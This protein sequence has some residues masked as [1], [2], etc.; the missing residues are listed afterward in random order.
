MI[1]TAVVVPC[2]DEATRL[3]ADA[4]ARFCRDTPWAS[5]VFVNDGSRDRTL[6]VL[7]S[8]AG[9]HP[10]RM[11]VID[12]QPNQGKAG[13]RVRPFDFVTAIVELDRVRRVYLRKRRD[14]TTGS[15]ADGSGGSR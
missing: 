3:P 13:S 15:G 12:Q 4:F 14:K 5:C 2:F 6:E 9:R 10:G 7:R 11:H 1:D 8:L